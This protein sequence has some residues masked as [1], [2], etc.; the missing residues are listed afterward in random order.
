MK[1][2]REELRKIIKEERE[3]LLNE[4]CRDE[5]YYG[6]E[7]HHDHAEDYGQYEESSMVSGNLRSIAER[8][9]KLSEMM[10]DVDSIEEWV[11]EKIAVAEAMVNSIYDYYR[12]NEETMDEQGDYVGMDPAQYDEDDYNDDGDD[13]YD[14]EYEDDDDD[15]TY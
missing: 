14:D 11:Q 8:A 3:K 13:S 5:M 6:N 15:Y 10:E 7:M 9:A 4:C 12:Y 1:V 2:T